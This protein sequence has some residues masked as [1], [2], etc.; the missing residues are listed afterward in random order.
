MIP[1]AKKP[2]LSNNLYGHMF[3]HCIL[4]TEKCIFFSDEKKMNLRL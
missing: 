2:F 1:I 4:N 3:V